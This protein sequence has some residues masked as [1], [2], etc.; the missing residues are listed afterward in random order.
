MRRRGLLA[1][2]LLAALPRAQASAQSFPSRPVRMIVPF[3]AGGISDLV[4]RIVAEAAGPILGQPIVVENRTGAGGNI[5]AE[6][7]AR[8]QPDGHTVLFSSIGM[9]AVNP[10]LYR[11]LPFDPAKDFATVAPLANTPHVLVVRPNLLPEGAG[12]REFLAMARAEP[13]KLGWS[14]AGAG[15]S[16]HQTLALLQSLGGVELMA[17][18]YRSGAAGVQAVLSGEVAATAEAT[19]VVVEHIRAGTLRALVAAAPE[20]LALLPTLPSAAEAGMPGL[21]NGSA[22]GI[23]VPRAT[24]E[25]VRAALDAAFTRAMAL[26]ELR[27]KL[28]AQGTVAMQGGAAGFDAMVVAEA[29]RWRKVLDGMTLD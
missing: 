23:V 12:L 2:P 20:R 10:I 3:G 22:A 6:A 9:L 4:A 25:P 11:R 19:P 29:A 18:H 13:G 5:A 7:A 17:V 27:A 21:V 24:P 8:A 16:P 26:P 15:S 14:T 1:A 28:A